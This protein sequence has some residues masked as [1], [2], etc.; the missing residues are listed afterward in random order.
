MIV[1]KAIGNMAK[2]ASVQKALKLLLA[3]LAVGLQFVPGPA[4]K[5]PPA[6][7]APAK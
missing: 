3:L 4:A 6:V 1:P 2:G 7:E 5:A